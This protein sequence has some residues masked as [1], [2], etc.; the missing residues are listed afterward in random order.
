MIDFI[1][2]IDQDLLFA[3]NGNHTPFLDDFMYIVTGKLVW[4]PFYAFLIFLMQRCF[5]W[6]RTGLALIGIALMI[7]MADQICSHVIRPAVCRLRPSNPDNPISQF[8]T[9]VHGVKAGRYGFPSCH[10]ANSAALATFLIMQFRTRAM[11]ILMVI[12]M[13]LLSYSRVY[14]GVHYP[15]D[16]LVGWLVG[17]FSAMTIWILGYK[18]AGFRSA[19]MER[20]LPAPDDP[21]FKKLI[22]YF[23]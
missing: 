16:I 14:M 3:A 8:I 20:P 9:L 5:G 7:L 13:L 12:W 6:K 11:T 23:N 17:S 10:A 1:I 15:T 21:F 18:L 4:I 2:E 19:R 22:N